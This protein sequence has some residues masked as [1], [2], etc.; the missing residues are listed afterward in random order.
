MSIAKKMKRKK[1]LAVR[2]KNGVD[3]NE[4]LKL[5]FLGEK[6][7][8][9]NL[10]RIEK[11]CHAYW[12]PMFCCV[13][14][15]KFG[16]GFDRMNKMHDGIV[17]IFDVLREP[18][19]LKLE[20]LEEGF[21]LECNGFKLEKLDRL[22]QPKSF[23]LKGFSEMYAYNASLTTLENLEIVWLWV[24]HDSFGFGKDRLMKAATALVKLQKMPE[25]VFNYILEDLEQVKAR[26]KNLDFNW[27]RDVMKEL[28]VE[29]YTF[30]D[31]LVLLR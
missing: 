31:G 15:K 30:D 29:G 22:K 12:L 16:F 9:K 23:T 13:M 5:N 4:I 6:I 19:F 28:S 1:T 17:H 24:L 26:G 8:E 21:Y 18:R 14:R 10:P 7:A 27:V 11:Y 20:W 25:K 2:K 3:R